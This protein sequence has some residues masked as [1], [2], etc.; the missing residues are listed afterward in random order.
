VWIAAAV[1]TILVPLVRYLFGPIGIAAYI[2]LVVVCLIL[3]ANNRPKNLDGA[4][5][6]RESEFK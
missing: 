3:G 4:E 2:G 5:E 1:L 6:F